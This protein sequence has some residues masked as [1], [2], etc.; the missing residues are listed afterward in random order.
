MKKT[1][2]PRNHFDFV[3]VLR[4]A[5][6]RAETAIV[7]IRSCAVH[8]ILAMPMLCTF[9]RTPFVTFP[10]CVRA[11]VC[12]FV[13]ACVRGSWILTSEDNTGTSV[14]VVRLTP[15]LGDVHNCK[16]SMV[17]RLLRWRLCKSDVMV[18]LG[19]TYS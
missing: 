4:L 6:C 10:L 11:Y 3:N 13:Y 16:M 12:A 15:V 7:R 19:Y 18:W 14:G 17:N 8:N 1:D 9:T 2:M 5:R